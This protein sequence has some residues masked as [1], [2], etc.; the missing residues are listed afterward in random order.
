M[1]KYI[2]LAGTVL[3]ALLVLAQNKINFHFTTGGS[4]SIYVT[5]IDTIRFKKGK[6][7]VEGPE[8]NYDISSVESATFSLD[9][10]SGGDTVFVTYNGSS[11]KVDNPFGDVEVTTSGAEVTV[12]SAANVKDIVYYL[13]GSS[14]NGFF[15]L[16]PDRGYTVVMD[17]LSLTSQD[18]APIQLNGAAD[19]ESYTCS[20]HLKGKNNVADGSG[21]ELKGAFYTK[22]KLKI[23]EDGSEGSLAITG[24]KKHA[25][26][27]SKNVELY[28]GA[29]TIDGAESDGINADALKLYGGELSIS[30]TK[31]DGVDCSERIL[32]EG[33]K[34][35]LSV[36]ADDTKGLKCDSVIEIKGGTIT[37]DVKGAGAKAIKSDLKTVVSGGT[38][39]ANLEASSAYH[40]SEADDYAF[41]A[42]FSSN[43]DI[44]ISDAANITVKGAGIA[45][46]ALNADGN[47]LMEGGSLTVSLSG[48][49]YAEIYNNG[50]KDTA[51]V[52]AVKAK[53]T[54]NINAGKVDLALGE[55]S[56]VSQGIK[57]DYVTIAGGEIKIN[58]Q[59]GFYYT[60]SSS[61]SSN[62]QGG[63]G[64]GFGGFGGGSTTNV[65]ASVPKAI[66]ADQRFV[67]TGGTI[68]ITVAHGK[69]IKSDKSIVLGTKNG[70]DN[71][72]TLTMNCGTSSDA[73]YTAN[74]EKSKKLPYCGPKAIQASDTVTVN[75]GTIDIVTLDCAIKGKYLT[76]NDGHL[77]LDAAND[78][79]LHGIQALT[80][81]GGNI[82]VPNSFEAFE[83]VT[84]TMN[85]GVT[86]CYSWDDGWNA[87]TSS[88]GS[89]SPM[90][91]VNGGYHYVRVGSGDTDCI[92]SNGG[93]KFTGGVLIVEGG[94]TL[95]GGDSGS[96]TFTYEGGKL[97]LF[98]SG[99]E[100]API[101]SYKNTISGVSKNT[102]Y[103]LTDNGTVLASF[104]PIAD[105]NSGGF[106]GGSG[107]SL[108]FLY[109]KAVSAVS[110]GNVSPEK[111]VTFRWRENG[112]DTTMEYYEGG[113]VNGG[114]NLSVTSQQL[115]TS[116]SGGG[117]G[118][119][120]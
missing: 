75:S 92:D 34:I 43:G 32:V 80:V 60:T 65:E 24:N 40:D 112:S 26:N 8:K 104:A 10:V 28:A 49:D 79:G 71:D 42:A 38:V 45:A 1:K 99:I 13:S 39:E 3:T 47:I 33:G 66:K 48:A 2:V 15:A 96:P 98:G 82:F 12:V 57:S 118:G 109:S 111:T 93:M 87:S 29:L 44:E 74:S 101:I 22:S 81:N 41:N 46:K 20:L 50:Q 76:V 91:I 59:G 103:T 56:N 116:S 86:S 62:N 107:K 21:N 25:L 77:T 102:R 117:P 83:G 18:Y 9:E 64:G 30:Q 54:V 37:A 72:Y 108:F 105:A 100:N 53:N 78:Q 90:V 35:S 85:G 51:V 55:K 119:R 73:T 114:S 120:W 69:G 4:E 68:D 88:S 31:G 14:T 61:S 11:V 67:L 106:G 63:W 27:S 115:T 19:G 52:C 36:S 84:I 94:S 58:N 7:I 97:L 17:Q 16:T 6:I 70:S 23:N 110:G 113:S 5:E 89:G 95:D